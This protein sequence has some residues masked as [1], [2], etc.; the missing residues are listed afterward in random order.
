MWRA[1]H[2]RIPVRDVSVSVRQPALYTVIAV[3]T[4]SVL[5][6]HSLSAAPTCVSFREKSMREGWTAL[7]KA[8]SKKAQR[9]ISRPSRPAAKG[10]WAPLRSDDSQAGHRVKRSSQSE[11]SAQ[12]SV[13]CPLE[14]N[15][16]M[17]SLSRSHISRTCP[18]TW[19]SPP[20]GPTVP[21]GP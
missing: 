9:E 5:V 2:V 6:S 15:D 19:K 18:V 13:A 11:I 16:V 4:F 21:S 1:A 10:R 7:V 20:F 3:V 8:V 17:T 14:E 12:R